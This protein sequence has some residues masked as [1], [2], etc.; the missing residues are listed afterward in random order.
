MKRGKVC[1]IFNK[2]LSDAIVNIKEQV[3]IGNLGETFRKK[4]SYLDVSDFAVKSTQIMARS[5]SD[6]DICVIF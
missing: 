5:P 3:T 4:V 1:I 2:G 6:I